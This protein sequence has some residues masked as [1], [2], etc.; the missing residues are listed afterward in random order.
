MDQITE[1]VG[2]SGPQS[3]ILHYIYEKSKHQ[4]VYQRDIECFFHILPFLVKKF[5][6]FEIRKQI[7]YICN[8]LLHLDCNIAL[9]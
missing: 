1:E 7:K 3:R 4:E 8:R 9:Q 2:L 5:F 6:D